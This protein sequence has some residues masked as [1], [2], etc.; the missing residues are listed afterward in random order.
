MDV[1]G[2][3][4]AALRVD[5]AFIDGSDIGVGRSVCRLDFLARRNTRQST[6]HRAQ[7]VCGPEAVHVF[8]GHSGF[9]RSTYEIFM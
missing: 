8:V 6:V 9:G 2:R 3:P 7:Q 1:T 5:H 4:Y